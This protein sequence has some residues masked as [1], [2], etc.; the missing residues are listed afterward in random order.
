MTRICVATWVCLLT[1]STTIPADEFNRS[2]MLIAF[3][4]FQPQFDGPRTGHGPIPR[5]EKRHLPT[6]WGMRRL[7]ADGKDNSRAVHVR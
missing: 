6:V 5:R 7:S 2:R 3:T 4:S 1:L